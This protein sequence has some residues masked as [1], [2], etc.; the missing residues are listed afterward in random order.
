MT[1][2]ER[3]ARAIGEQHVRRSWDQ[4]ESEALK[5][6]FRA[7]ARAAIAAMRAPTEKMIASG[8]E[9]SSDFDREIREYITIPDFMARDI[10][11]AMIEAALTSEHQSAASPNT[12]GQPKAGGLQNRECLGVMDDPEHA[13]GEKI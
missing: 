4:I 11:F 9:T 6:V 3:V 13:T 1:M 8:V 7:S 12:G 10:W 2:I 5:G